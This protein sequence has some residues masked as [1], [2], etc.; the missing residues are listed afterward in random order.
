[1]KPDLTIFV[2]MAA[3]I[4][5]VIYYLS[6]NNGGGGGTVEQ[7]PIAYPSTP[8][9]G[10]WLPGGVSTQFRNGGVGASSPEVWSN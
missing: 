2:A 6:Q 4:V 10:G 8:I 1:M 9:T 7:K 3:V 5:G